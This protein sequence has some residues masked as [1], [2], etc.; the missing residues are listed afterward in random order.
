MIKINK[1]SNTLPYLLSVFLLVTLS[2]CD[3]SKTASD[4]PSSTANNGQV[5][6]EKNGKTTQNDAES[7]VRKKQL[8]ADIR[9]REQRNN[10]GGDPKKRA[11]EDLSSEVRSKLEANI[12]KGKLTVSAKNAD[13]TVSG[14]VSTQA[15]LDK[16]KALGME[17]KGVKSV[18]V[19]ATVTP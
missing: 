7:D 1:F 12:P 15:E 6:T 11:D 13:V 16:I 18:I 3:T 2:A 9:A 5:S 14:V 8:E 10:V 4:A 17:I 19:K